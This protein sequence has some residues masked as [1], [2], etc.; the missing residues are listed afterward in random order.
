LFGMNR[1]LLCAPGRSLYNS[2]DPT[3]RRWVTSTPAQ[4]TISVDGV[5]H[6]DYESPRDDA[7]R[8][9]F[10]ADAW[11]VAADHILVSA[12]HRGYTSLPGGPVVGRT[13]WYDRKNTFVILDWGVGTAEHEFTVGFNLPGADASA[14]ADGRIHSQQPGGNVQIL[15]LPAPGQT[16][17]RQERFWSPIY[18]QKVPAVRYAVTQKG[19]QALFAHVVSVFDGAQP[20]A[21]SAR[22]EAPP[23]FGKPVQIRIL[24][25]GQERLIDLSPSWDAA[26][27]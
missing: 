17:A 6:A 27:K 15:T 22:W 12:H 7:G 18:G 14:I 1:V 21:V 23:V 19:T 11:E 5:N 4:N 16:L 3:D 24:T 10:H 20:P 2:A 9:N 8:E 13:I 25:G 26:A